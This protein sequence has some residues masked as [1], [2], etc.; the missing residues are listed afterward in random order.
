MQPYIR[1]T[2]PSNIADVNCPK[3]LAI[4]VV[5]KGGASF[6]EDEIAIKFSPA[7]DKTH[8]I[9]SPVSKPLSRL[10]SEAINAIAN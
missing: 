8:V 9:S 6:M 7:T 2:S 1:V 5:E 3:P 10:D 4:N